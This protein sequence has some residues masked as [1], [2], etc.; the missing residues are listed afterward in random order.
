MKRIIDLIA[1][2]IGLCFTSS[3]GKDLF[4]Q[5]LLDGNWG[6]VRDEMVTSINGEV[7]E[8]IITDCDP[9]HPRDEMDTQLAIRKIS[10]NEYEFSEYYW[11]RLGGEW[12]FSNRETYILRNNVLFMLVN[13]RE[14]EYGHFSVSASELSIE[15]IFITEELIAGVRIQTSTISRRVYRRLSNL[16]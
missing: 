12:V 2:V 3:C 9:F 14:T 7:T 11:N 8:P 16:L 1:A 10:G 4:E 15:S 13:G 5:V 6:L